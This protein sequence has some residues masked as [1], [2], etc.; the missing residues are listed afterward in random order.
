MEVGEY[1]RVVN[2]LAQRTEPLEDLTHFSMGFVREYAEARRAAKNIDYNYEVD[3]KYRRLDHLTLELGDMYFYATALALRT[4]EMI[5]WDVPR[6]GL[7]DLFG[8]RYSQLSWEDE[9]PEKYAAVQIGMSTHEY[10]YRSVG[11]E[12]LF[13]NEELSIATE[14]LELVLKWRYHKGIL[15]LDKMVDAL[16]E[17]HGLVYGLG[18]RHGISMQLI[19][20]RN[21]QKLLRR[22]PNGFRGIAWKHDESGP[23]STNT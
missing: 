23:E 10:R 17:A 16:Y 13:S 1:L 3:G 12:D 5:E 8:G 19:A 7:S 11:V 18:V 22:H 14:P 15:D 20:E 4:Q 2:H 6:Q 9:H 21:M